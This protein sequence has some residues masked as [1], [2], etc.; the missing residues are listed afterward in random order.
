LAISSAFE[1]NLIYRI[2]SYHKHHMI[3]LSKWHQGIYIMY[4][5]TGTVSVLSVDERRQRAT[6]ILGDEMN[7][8][9]QVG[10]CKWS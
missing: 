8:S 3:T 1:H 4:K 10:Q 6:T 9:S 7:V 2:V 5:L